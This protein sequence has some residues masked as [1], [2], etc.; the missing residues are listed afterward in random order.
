VRGRGLTWINATAGRLAYAI[1]M[2]QPISTAPFDVDLELAVVD[3]AGEH[4]LAFP[5]RR[6][7]TD[8]WL[9]V[10]TSKHIVVQPTHWRQWAATNPKGRLH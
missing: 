1:V 3:G 2:W 5:C 9:D 4:A 6:S 10:L 7:G 8:S